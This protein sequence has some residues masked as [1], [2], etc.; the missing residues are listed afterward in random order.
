MEKPTTT[1]T[2]I[3]TSGYHSDNRSVNQTDL[4]FP[5]YRVE[6]DPQELFENMIENNVFDE[7]LMEQL[8]CQVRNIMDMIENQ[9]DY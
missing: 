3:S 7:D 2:T 9:E 4:C 5:G 8:I 1:T 6:V